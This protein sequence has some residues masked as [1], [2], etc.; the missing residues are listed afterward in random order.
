[1]NEIP[2]R[3]SDQL[4]AA[5]LMERGYFCI[6]AI[7][8]KDKRFPDRMD[9]LFADVKEPK[10]VEDHFYRYG[11]D[12]LSARSLLEKMRT[13]RHILRNSVSEDELKALGGE[14]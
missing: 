3:T 13:T 12:T 5:Y 2:Y 9:F 4:F 14:Q 7:P 10:S 8:S 11:K 6:S 1:M